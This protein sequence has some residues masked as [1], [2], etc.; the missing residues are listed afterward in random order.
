VHPIG[1][2]NSYRAALAF[3]DYLGSLGIEAG[4][5]QEAGYTTIW[6]R[7]PVDIEPATYELQRF[8][9]EPDHPRYQVASWVSGEPDANL[10]GSALKPTSWFRN[11]LRRTGP[12]TLITCGLAIAIT[13]LTGFGTNHWVHA[14]TYNAPLILSGEVYRLLTPL[15]LHFPILGIPFLHLLFNLMWIWD[16]GGQLERR[17]GSTASAYHIVTIGLVSNTCQYLAE[18]RVIF[19]GLSGVVYGL[20][21]YFWLRGLI[22]SRF[23]L[24]VNPNLL[25]FLLLWMALGFVNVIPGMADMA[26]L[27]GFLAGVALAFLDVKVFKFRRYY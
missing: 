7:H 19:G 17:L 13:L 24:K 9:N 23:G 12:V 27:G 3:R 1:R 15:F 11:L 8:F 16:L 4:L 25:T 20:L 18:P 6:V 22:D 5:Q 21:G 14:F 10:G 26:H 2:I